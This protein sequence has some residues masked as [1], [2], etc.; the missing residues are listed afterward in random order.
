MSD[1]LPAEIGAWIECAQCGRIEKP[2]LSVRIPAGIAS[3][4]LEKVGVA[5][6]RCAAPAMMYLHRAVRQM[7]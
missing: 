6:D 3:P 4:R 1:N 2:T 7:P 5:C